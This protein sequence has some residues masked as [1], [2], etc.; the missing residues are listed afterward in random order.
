MKLATSSL[1]ISF[2]L[3]TDKRKKRSH[4]I[5]L[6]KS[7]TITKHE[8]T[9]YTKHKS[10]KESRWC[11]LEGS[12]LVLP[13]NISVKCGVEVDNLP[14]RHQHLLEVD[15]FF[16]Y[17]DADISPGSLA[18]LSS[19]KGSLIGTTHWHATTLDELL[20]NPHLDYMD[21]Q[22]AIHAQSLQSH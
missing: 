1:H 5:F 20:L 19:S 4:W 6:W 21:P 16:V 13:L 12:F 22:A 9:T 18:L 7:T 17:L 8:Q 11:L 15:E 3:H 2:T 10:W 14:H